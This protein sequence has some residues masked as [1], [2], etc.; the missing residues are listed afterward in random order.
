VHQQA[1]LVR[2][3]E[4]L[5]VTAGTVFCSRLLLLTKK[6]NTSETL[7]RITTF[8]SSLLPYAKRSA[9]KVRISAGVVLKPR[10]SKCAIAPQVCRALPW[11][12]DHRSP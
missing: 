12:R 5:S 3:T 7:N 8:L 4:D 2:R 10:Q 1:V 6:R 11:E 9:H